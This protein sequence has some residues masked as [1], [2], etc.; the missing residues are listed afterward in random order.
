MYLAGDVTFGARSMAATSEVEPLVLGLAHHLGELSD[1]RRH[2]A[3]V[4]GGLRHLPLPLATRPQM[5]RA[6]SPFDAVFAA[7][8]SA[9]DTVEAE[10]P[11]VEPPRSRF[12][13]RVAK[14][15]SPHRPTR[16]NY[17]YFEELNEALAV[18]RVEHRAT[19]EG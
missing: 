13:V 15:G 17:D 6:Y 16:R 3:R 1:R 10:A 2:L 14:I 5:P 18:Q 19:D 4:I 9:S 12:M 7:V 11:R 8:A